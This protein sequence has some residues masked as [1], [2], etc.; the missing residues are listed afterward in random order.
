VDRL[1]DAG[2][3]EGRPLLRVVDL[4]TGGAAVSQDDASRHP[5]LGLY[6]AAVDAGG[7]DEVA[8]GA[9]S[10]GATLVYVGTSSVRV[11]T[12]HQAAL[13]DEPEWVSALVEDVADVVTSASMCATRNELCR[14]C[15]VR[16]SC[17]AQPEGAVVG[18]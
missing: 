10:A 12:R 16:R 6:Q 7:F 2:V 18:A 14:S 13:G 8:P 4:K 9:R 11:T 15:P 5:Q 1:E 3:D 17:P